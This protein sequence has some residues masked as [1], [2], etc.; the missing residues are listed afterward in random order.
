[1]AHNRVKDVQ[2][3]LVGFGRTTQSIK[4]SL[5]SVCVNV[6]VGNKSRRHIHQP[7]KWYIRN[8]AVF[9]KME[10]VILEWSNK[11]SMN[12]QLIEA[13]AEYNFSTITSL[14]AQSAS[15]RPPT[16]GGGD[17]DDDDTPV[18]KGALALGDIEAI[19]N[20]WGNV[21]RISR[22]L[23]NIKAATRLRCTRRRQLLRALYE[24]KKK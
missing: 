13:S 23:C 21:S 2:M 20:T 9:R 1:M 10:T 6:S 17:D 5:F 22:K 3:H 15:T 7:I 19:P 14:H 24:K 11:P 18:V 12:I 16:S 8:G 4:F